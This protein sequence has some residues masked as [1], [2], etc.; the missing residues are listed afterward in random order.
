[1]AFRSNLGIQYWFHYAI[2]H[3]EYKQVNWNLQIYSFLG[4]SDKRY[5]LEYDAFI[6]LLP[7]TIELIWLEY[8]GDIRFNHLLIFGILG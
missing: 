4:I 1:M 6:Y 5:F 2:H 8:K 7:G 3:G